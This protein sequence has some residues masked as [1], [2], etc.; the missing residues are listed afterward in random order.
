MMAICRIQQISNGTKQSAACFQIPF[1]FFC[2]LDPRKRESSCDLYLIVSHQLFGPELPAALPATM[3]KKAAKEAQVPSKR[4][5]G[6]SPPEAT[7]KKGKSK[8]SEKKEKKKVKNTKVETAS[9]HKVKKDKVKTKPVVE[10]A[11]NPKTGGTGSKTK[12]P[13][14]NVK[15]TSTKRPP[16]L[17]KADAKD[18]KVTKRDLTEELEKACTGDKKKPA[19]VLKTKLEELKRLEEEASSSSEG[20]SDSTGSMT[21]HLAALLNKPKAAKPVTNQEESS[22]AD[23]DDEGGDHDASDNGSDDGSNDE[24]SDEPS[25]DDDG[26]D[27][28]SEEDGQP[29]QPVTP[30]ATQD[31][32]KDKDNKDNKDTQSLAIVAQN[33]EKST[34]LV[35]N[36]PL[37]FLLT[38]T[39]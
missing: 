6:K 13:E 18:V 3:A 4:V 14:A 5:N 20:G 17:R 9:T 21:E 34:A 39:F 30:M 25:G 28:S 37:P 2:K 16:A 33:T 10:K 27:E 7:S 1:C 23:S 31:K 38:M 12:Q 32:D 8:T 19:A 29:S 26:E 15:G 36:S 11:S 22:D 35:R 24:D